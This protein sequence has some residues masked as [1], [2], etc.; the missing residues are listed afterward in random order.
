M[1]LKG[2]SLQGFR[3]VIRSSAVA[4]CLLLAMVAQTR[5]DFPQ[6]K[7]PSVLLTQRSVCVDDLATPT[8]KRLG[9]L[10][11]SSSGGPV[12]AVNL[13]EALMRVQMLSMNLAIPP[14]C[15]GLELYTLLF[16]DG[17]RV[18]VGIPDDGSVSKSPKWVAVPITPPG[19][20][21]GTALRIE[22]LR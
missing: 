4:L 21:T 1:D 7:A 9:A 2:A 19:T 18:M 14:S 3:S 16:A 12:D 15:A 8:A 6:V 5:I 11:I 13:S 17:P 20:N 10:R 22:Q